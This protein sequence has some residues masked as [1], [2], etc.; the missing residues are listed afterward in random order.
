MQDCRPLVIAYIANGPTSLG[1]LVRNQRRGRSAGLAF[2]R[3][4]CL[5][6]RIAFYRV[7]KNVTFPLR[8]TPKDGPSFCPRWG[9]FFWRLIGVA[10]APSFNNIRSDQKGIL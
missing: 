1:R 10:K 2:G 7:T 5:T 8:Y 9:R 4:I 3:G 6:E